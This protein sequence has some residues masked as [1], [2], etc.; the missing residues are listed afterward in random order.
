VA[1]RLPGGKAVTFST[2]LDRGRQILATWHAAKREASM[3]DLLG[4]WVSEVEP[5]MV[6]QRD[7]GGIA[8]LVGL[9]YAGRVIVPCYPC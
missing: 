4:Q 9:G 7:A 5:E 6:F 1:V 2:E 3:R 8:W